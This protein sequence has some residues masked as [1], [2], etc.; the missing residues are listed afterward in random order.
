MNEQERGASNQDAAGLRPLSE[1][2]EVWVETREMAAQNF[3]N[4]VE[5][6]AWLKARGC[7]EILQWLRAG[8]GI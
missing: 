4:R 3:Q 6:V 2:P 5:P 8:G 1:P 7:E